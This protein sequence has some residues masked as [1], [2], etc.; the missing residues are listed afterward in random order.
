MGNLFEKVKY[1]FKPSDE[2]VY[3]EKTLF[4]EIIVIRYDEP[5]IEEDWEI[6]SFMNKGETE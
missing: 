5:K 4:P 2:I 1:F 3:Q 6:P